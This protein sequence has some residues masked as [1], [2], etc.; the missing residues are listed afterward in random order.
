MVEYED[1]DDL[2]ER[3]LDMLVSYHEEY[4]VL[5]LDGLQFELEYFE[6]VYTR[7]LQPVVDRDFPGVLGAVGCIAFWLDGVHLIDIVK[8]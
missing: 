1:V 4:N 8:F 7:T 6:I 2:K 5:C 3:M